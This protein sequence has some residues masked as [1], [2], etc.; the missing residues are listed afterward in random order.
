M[1]IDK[2]EIDL[3]EFVSKILGG[4]VIGAV[5]TLRDI[6]EGWEKIEITVKR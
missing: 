1:E 3:N 2:R 5:E 6:P 4:M